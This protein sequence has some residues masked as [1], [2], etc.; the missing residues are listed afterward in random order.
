MAF[1]GERFVVLDAL[2]IPCPPGFSTLSRGTCIA[3]STSGMAN[4]FEANLACRAQG[5]RLCTFGEWVAACQKDPGFFATV[6]VA[7]W[8]DHAANSTNSAKFVGYGDNGFNVIGGS[9]CTFGGWTQADTG[10]QAIRC[11]K[12]R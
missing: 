6:P 1:D 3:D 7:E 12:D 10:N 8:V 5:G 2:P 11:C 9:G 4:F